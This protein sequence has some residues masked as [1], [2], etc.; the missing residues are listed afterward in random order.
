MP[1]FSTASKAHLSNI[2]PDLQRVLNRAIKDFDFKIICS[3]RGELEQN[4]L[5]KI[6]KTRA[7]FGKSPHNF[8]PALAVDIAPWPIDWDNIRAFE[9]MGKV[10]LRCALEE[11]VLINWGKYFKGLVDYPHFELYRWQQMERTTV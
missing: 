8:R 6:G 7:S 10:I 1:K 9:L 11:N 4:R 2:H 5:Y 3:V